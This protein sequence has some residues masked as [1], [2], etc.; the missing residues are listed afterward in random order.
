MEYVTDESLILNR[1][2]QTFTLG[3]NSADRFQ[4]FLSLLIYYGLEFVYF[5]KKLIIFFG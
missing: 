5:V 4:V 1:K 2:N 3:L